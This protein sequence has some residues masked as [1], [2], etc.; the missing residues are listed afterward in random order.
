MKTINNKYKKK[1][2]LT[3]KIKKTI[4]GM[5]NLTVTPVKTKRNQTV[6]NPGQVTPSRYNDNSQD[7]QELQ[8]LQKS[9]ELFDIRLG[10]FSKMTKTIKETS[11]MFSHNLSELEEIQKGF[12]DEMSTHVKAISPFCSEFLKKLQELEPKDDINMEII[13]RLTEEFKTRQKTGGGGGGGAAALVEQSQ[14]NQSYMTNSGNEN[15]GL[16]LYKSLLK[17]NSNIPEFTRIIS[18]INKYR[19]LQ[20]LIQSIKEK[21]ETEIDIEDN[22]D[23]L[24]ELELDTKILQYRKVLQQIDRIRLLD[25]YLQ[26]NPKH[27]FDSLNT[28]NLFLVIKKKEIDMFLERYL[29]AKFRPDT[30][31]ILYNMNNLRHE[32]S[33]I[34][35]MQ[36]ELK[37]CCE[38]KRLVEK[39]PRN[40]ELISDAIPPPPLKR[41]SS[42]QIQGASTTP[43]AVTTPFSTYEIA[44]SGSAN[45][46]PIMYRCIYI[47]WFIRI[48]E[49]YISDKTSYDCLKEILEYLKNELL[50]V[51]IEDFIEIP[52]TNILPILSIIND[53]VNSGI[54]KFTSIREFFEFVIPNQEEL[55]SLFQQLCQ[56]SASGGG[57]AAMGVEF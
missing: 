29:K 17:C 53:S 55:F 14:E 37:I 48:A 51:D 49:F 12:I 54:F 40:E 38:Q 27:V 47:L 25:T 10:E 50:K 11:D 24:N 39:R 5:F 31:N 9:R 46:N 21:T 23:S 3:K 52:N 6:T 26:Y 56:P 35:R 7:L 2:H 42:M 13:N 22:I 18:F 30:N 16:D 1:I 34:K 57:G 8:N 33:E 43:V 36:T 44:S 41:V 28:D 15:E 4:G 32:I 19:L 45:T 20:Q